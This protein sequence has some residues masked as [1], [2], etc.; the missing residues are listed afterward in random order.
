MTI[1]EL[2][3]YLQPYCKAIYK[4]GSQLLKLN[5]CRDN[6][7]VLIYETD[8]DKEEMQELLI[9]NKEYDFHYNKL[10]NKKIRVWSYLYGLLEYLIGEHI[11]FETDILNADRKQ[12]VECCYRHIVN[13]DSVATISNRES[14]GWYYLLTGVYMLENNSYEISFIQ[15]ANIQLAHDKQASDDLKNYVRTKIKYYRSVL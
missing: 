9:N 5:N 7:I 2:Y 10:G 6:D 8:S 13:L 1:Q 14:K 11:T 4:T 3:N 15:K 12:Y